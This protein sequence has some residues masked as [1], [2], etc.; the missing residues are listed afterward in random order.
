MRFRRPFL[1]ICSAVAAQAFAGSAL[2]QVIPDYLENRVP[3]A[4]SQRPLAEHKTVADYLLE[5][6]VIILRTRVAGRFDGCQKFDDVVFQDHSV[7]EC[8]QVS[9]RAELTPEVRILRKIETG[10]QVIVIGDHP[11][12]GRLIIKKGVLLKRAIHMGDELLGVPTR[13]AEHRRSIGP[14][15]VTNGMIPPIPTN[16]PLASGVIRENSAD[17]PNPPPYTQTLDPITLNTARKLVEEG[18]V[19]PQ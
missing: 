3:T 16:Q 7:F 6:W 2:A 5:G 4:P 1:A 14:V 15:D 19:P 8:L 11:Y 10:E 13:N 18:L 12:V 17:A 9:T